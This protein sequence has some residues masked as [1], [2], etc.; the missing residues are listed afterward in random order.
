MQLM[1]T[2]CSLK[3]LFYCL[4]M[5]ILGTNDGFTHQVARQ[6][7][8]NAKDGRTGGGVGVDST[9]ALTEQT[10]ANIAEVCSK[11]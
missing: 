6:M 11:S 3:T 8:S 4:Q 1:T 9:S 10:E 2:H 5:L 7:L